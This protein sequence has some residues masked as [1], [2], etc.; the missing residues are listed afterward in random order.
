MAYKFTVDGRWMTNDA[1]LTEADRGF[2][3]YVPTHAR[4]TVA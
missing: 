1:K 4:S 2:I 3:I